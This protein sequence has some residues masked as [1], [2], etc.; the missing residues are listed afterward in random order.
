MIIL[1]HQRMWLILLR[2]I[3]RSQA[4]FRTHRKQRECQK[5]NGEAMK[6]LESMAPINGS[7]G[8]GILAN[9]VP[10]LT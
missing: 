6:D 5:K 3:F 2:H 10:W 4:N 8:G 7:C 9:P 1:R